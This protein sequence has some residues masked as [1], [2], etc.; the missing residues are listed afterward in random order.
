MRFGLILGL[1]ALSLS[2]PALAQHKNAAPRA[3]E[4]VDGR[5]D[6]SWVEAGDPDVNA[7]MAKAQDTSPDFIAALADPDAF[8]ITFKF[9]LG[10]YEHIW[11]KGVGRDG[12]F[13]TGVLDNVPIQKGWA[14]GDTVRVPIAEMSDYFYCD[15]DGNPHGHFTTA[16]FIDREQGKGFTA[17]VL[18]RLCEERVEFNT[19]E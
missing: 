19:N 11:V 7:A 17:G 12:A 8:N 14:K 10:G 3:N 5:A 2:A 1:A 16:V 4:P 15:G 18:P 13:L 9:P 6:V